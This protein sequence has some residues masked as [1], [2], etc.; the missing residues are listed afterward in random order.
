ML[1]RST[2]VFIL[3]G[4]LIAGIIGYNTFLQNQPPVQ[5]TIAVDPS[6]SDW[7]RAQAEAFNRTNPVILPS[8]TRVQIVITDAFNDIAVWQGRANWT[9]ENHPIGWIPTSSLIQQYIPSNLTFRPVVTSLAQ[10]PLVWGG[11][12]SRVNIITANGARPFDWAAVQTIA[13]G[14]RW[15]NLGAPANWGNVNMGLNWASSSTSGMGVLASMQASYTNNPQLDERTSTQADFI[16]W[17]TPLNDAMQNAER[18]GGS[19]ADAMSSRGATVA[20]FALLPEFQWLVELDDLNRVEPMQFAYPQYGFMLD[21]PLLIWQD[22]G[23]TE[24]ETQSLQQF[25]NW[26]Q[27]DQ[28]TLTSAQFGLRPSNGVPP[29]N[30]PLFTNGEAYG[31]LRELPMNPM[32]TPDR[33]IAEQLLRLLQ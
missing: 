9:S 11:F 19:P 33:R 32:V 10:S 14:Q 23:T 4:V 16:T 25:A 2:L 1:R 6:I 27:G 29:Q 28:G 22:T 15:E 18:L 17:F 7:A 21:F 8:S 30:H 12:G 24:I 26:I 13:N 5:I 3:F 31:I 20:D